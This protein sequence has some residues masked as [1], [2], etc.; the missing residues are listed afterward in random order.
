MKKIIVVM[1]VSILAILSG[2]AEKSSES[3][4]QT[5]SSEIISANDFDTLGDVQLSIKDGTL[6]KTGCTLV[7]KNDTQVNYKF[8][9][10]Y[11]IYQLADGKITEADRISSGGFNLLSVGLSAKSQKEEIIQWDWLYNNL[12]SGTYLLTRQFDASDANGTSK[13]LFVQFEIE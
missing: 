12:A 3:K 11:H 7:M 1:F 13:M 4:A 8:G 5:T 2:C 10:E 6:S 9:T